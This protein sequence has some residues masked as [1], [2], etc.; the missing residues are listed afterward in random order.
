MNQWIGRSGPLFF[1]AE[2]HLLNTEGV[3]E[4][5]NRHW[6]ISGP[7]W[8]YVRQWMMT[9]AGEDSRKSRMPARSLNVSPKT[10]LNSRVGNGHPVARESR[11]QSPA[12]TP[13]TSRAP[14]MA[15]QEGVY[16]IFAL[17]AKNVRSQYNHEKTLDTT[18]WRSNVQNNWAGLFKSVE[19]VNGGADGGVV[20]A[21]RRLRRRETEYNK[22]PWI[23][24]Q[25][26]KR[27]LAKRVER[28]EWGLWFSKCYC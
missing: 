20:L 8:Q 10:C 17:L 25:N 18:K 6:T 13:W 15:H 5:E 16:L 11:S 19:V 4:M 7:S 9:W 28:S 27:T 12:V 22:G 24:S 26:K 23:R 1:P 3:R 21:W 14:H 2:L